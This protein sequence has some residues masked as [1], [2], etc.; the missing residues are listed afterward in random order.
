MAKAGGCNRTSDK[1]HEVKAA[2]VGGVVSIGSKRRRQMPT[3]S[4]RRYFFI[5]QWADH[6][7]DDPHGTDFPNA[8]AALKYAE[9]I[10]R[11]LKEAGGYDDPSLKMIVK[12]A[13]GGVVH[14]IPF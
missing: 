12:D 1:A 7:H 3:H 5:L 8:G 4:A 2:S 9:Q 10:I 13:D 14:V 11:E 6:L